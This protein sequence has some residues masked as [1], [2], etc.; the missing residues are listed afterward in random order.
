MDWWYMNHPENFS[1]NVE[2]DDIINLAS[3]Q[4]NA[5]RRRFS[6]KYSQI[7]YKNGRMVYLSNYIFYSI[8]LYFILSVAYLGILFIGPRAQT[9]TAYYKVGVLIVLVLFPYV[10]TPIEMFF[11]KMF[12][13]IVET[14]IGNVYERPDYEYVI[15]YNAVPN[16]FSY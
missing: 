3:N 2:K 4:N 8:W 13:F 6:T 11:L 7:A 5:M 12:T 16:L 9:F 10:A 14:L 15:D 1:M